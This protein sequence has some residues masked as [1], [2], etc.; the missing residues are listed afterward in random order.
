MPSRSTASSTFP[1]FS[2]WFDAIAR[3]ATT[4][5]LGTK[6][7]PAPSV[8]MAPADVAARFAETALH[9]VAASFGEDDVR[10]TASGKVTFRVDVKV[11]GHVIAT[12][13]GGSV[14][15]APDGET[16]A[17]IAQFGIVARYRRLGLGSA[18]ARALF[19]WLH[20]EHGVTRIVF[21][22]PADRQERTVARSFAERIGAIPSGNLG[23]DP[24]APPVFTWSTRRA[25]ARR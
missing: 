8:E 15:I 17:E 3:V 23:G 6:A 24:L 14:S 16:Q 18:V 12:V 13:R 9:C 22:A 10:R 25:F 2:R 21:V 20:R 1:T 11:A 4:P 19:R 5:I 7:A